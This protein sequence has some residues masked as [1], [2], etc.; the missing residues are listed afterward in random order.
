MIAL[1]RAVNDP[2]RTLNDIFAVPRIVT[3]LNTDQFTMSV[4]PALD[5]HAA[6]TG[7][8]LVIAVAPVNRLIKTVP[9]W[10][11]A[12]PAIARCAEMKANADITAIGRV[13]S[14]SIVMTVPVIGRV[15]TPAAIMMPVI[16]SVAVTVTVIMSAA[17]AVTIAVPITVAMSIFMPVSIAMSIMTAVT[18]SVTVMPLVPIAAIGHLQPVS[19]G[20]PIGCRCGKL[21]HGRRLAQSNV[22]GRCGLGGR[23]KSKGG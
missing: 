17:V 10:G 1:V 9:A 7:A 13:M 19:I 23:S 3:H 5:S 21:R 8:G 12:I 20:M 14:M 18:V 2:L 22:Q 4:V 11:P 6:A 15:M 16:M